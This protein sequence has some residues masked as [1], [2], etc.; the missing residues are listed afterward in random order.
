MPF[1]AVEYANMI[2]CWEVCGSDIAAVLR[3]YSETYPDSQQPAS[4]SHFNYDT[5]KYRD[6]TRTGMAIEMDTASSDTEHVGIHSTSTRAKL[7]AKG[8]HPQNLYFVQIANER[9]NH[10]VGFEMICA[11]AITCG[12]FV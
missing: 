1:T 10:A 5:F 2:Y 12:L 9:T 8:D 7:G 6:E 3:L 11:C 4:P